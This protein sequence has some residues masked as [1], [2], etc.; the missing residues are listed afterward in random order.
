MGTVNGEPNACK[1][2][3]DDEEGGGAGG[4]SGEEEGGGENGVGGA[5]A[6][7]AALP[8]VRFT[9]SVAKGGRLLAFECES[10][11]EFVQILHVSLEDLEP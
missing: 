7:A 1:D 4:S 10:S 9:V 3:D 11:G 5:G 2:E 8:P 6:S